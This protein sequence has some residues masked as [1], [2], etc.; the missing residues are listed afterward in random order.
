VQ[1]ACFIS[2]EGL[3]CEAKRMENERQDR[4]SLNLP[5]K[6]LCTVRDYVASLYFPFQVLCSVFALPI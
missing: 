4:S 2:K 3:K 6:R 5:F 1:K